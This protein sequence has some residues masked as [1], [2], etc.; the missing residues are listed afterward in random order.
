MREVINRDKTTELAKE[1]LFSV[2][3]AGSTLQTLAG[4]V[5]DQKIAGEAYMDAEESMVAYM[6][7]LRELLTEE[8]VET[9]LKEGAQRVIADMVVKGMVEKGE[10]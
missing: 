1:A 3:A 2:V 4:Y 9:F 5:R 6:N 10:E 7:L 8:E